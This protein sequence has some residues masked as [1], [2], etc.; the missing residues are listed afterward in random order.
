MLQVEKLPKK[1]NEINYFQKNVLTRGCTMYSVS[2][3]NDITIVVQMEE[4]EIEK[5][6]CV[7]SHTL[8]MCKLLA[9]LEKVE[10]KNGTFNVKS[11]KGKYKSNTIEHILSIPNKDFEIKATVDFDKL[12]LAKKFTSSNDTRPVL[13]GININSKGEIIGTDSFFVY[14]VTTSNVTNG[15]NVIIPQK[16]IDFVAKE[17]SGEVTMYLG[18]LSCML[19]N[20]Q[21]V[22][23]ITRLI[24]GDFPN[25]EPIYVGK[26]RCNDIVLDFEDFI[27]K[28]NLAKEVSKNDFELATIEFTNGRIKVHGE[29]EFE[30]EIITECDF[31]FGFVLAIS[32]FDTIVSSLEKE[33]KLVFKYFEN[34]QPIYIDNANN[35]YIILPIRKI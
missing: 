4:F 7:N 31:E 24:A 20:E 23:Y 13:N 33:E 12:L 1:L 14:R 9:P 22:R 19:I 11:K 26:Q 21:G 27:S 34:N 28:Y 16:F 18:K 2:K 8:E 10:I 17:F 32:K 5:D 29:N 6:F 25:V 35:E 3:K 15:I 30:T